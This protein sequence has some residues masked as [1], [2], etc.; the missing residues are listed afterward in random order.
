MT[1]RP[2]GYLSKPQEFTVGV[3][4]SVLFGALMA[5][6]VAYLMELA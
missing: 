6:F 4:V 5:A 2:V 1:R 3:I